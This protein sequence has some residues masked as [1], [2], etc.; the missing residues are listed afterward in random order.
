M[1][2]K[3]IKVDYNKFALVRDW[4]CIFTYKSFKCP[5]YY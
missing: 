1:K 5:K 2:S 4:A 3:A